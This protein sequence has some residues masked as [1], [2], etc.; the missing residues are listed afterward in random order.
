MKLYYRDYV[1]ADPRVTRHEQGVP[2]QERRSRGGACQSRTTYHYE[3][4]QDSTYHPDP[5]PVSI[6]VCWQHLA[7][8]MHC[9]YRQARR[10]SESRLS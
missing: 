10:E 6:D 8:Y 3:G 5:R 1:H 7:W 4:M 9:G 2:C